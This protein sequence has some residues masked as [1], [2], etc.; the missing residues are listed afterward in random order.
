[1]QSGPRAAVRRLRAIKKA[2]ISWPPLA[3]GPIANKRGLWEGPA[4]ASISLQRA[5]MQREGS[6][7]LQKT[8]QSLPIG[9]PCEVNA[10]VVWIRAFE[11]RLLSW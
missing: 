2:E 1:M 10:E 5:R 11:T 7:S 9:W 8:P 3:I 6:C 4:P